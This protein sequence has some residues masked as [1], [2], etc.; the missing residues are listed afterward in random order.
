[1]S[2]ALGVLVIVVG[3]VVSVALHEIGHMVPAKRFGVLVP[4][5]S[6]GFGPVLWQ[7]TWRGTTYA[8]RAVLLGG[9]VRIVGMF[10]P[11]RPGTRTTNRH[12]R[13]TLAQE[14]R[15]ASAEEVPP[16]QESHA[17]HRLSAPRKVVV[18]ASGPATNL[19]ICIALLAVAMMGIGLA[20]PS[21]TLQETTATVSTSAGDVEGPARGAGIEAG[22]TVISWDGTATPSWQDLR[23]AIAASDGAPVPV[24]VERAGAQVDLTVT[25]VRNAQGEWAAGIIAG[26][27]YVSTGPGAVASTTWQMFTGTASVVVR[28]P[29][30]VWGVG[31]SLFT[32][33]ER[34]PNGVVSVVGVGRVAG[35]ITQ[36]GDAAGA[37][38]ARQT[39]A[40]LLALLASLNMALFVFNLIPL[41]PL[42]GGHVAGA[43]YEGVRRTWARLRGAPDP[44]PAD[45]ARMMPL[46]HAVVGLL[47]AMT[48]LL[49][50]AD[51]VDPVRLF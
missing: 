15:L 29:Q 3:L 50:A 5:Y 27:D 30:A 42:D 39:A 49:V 13:P 40:S 20:T 17:F 32:S 46:T 23:T 44:G 41:P 26:I 9:Y 45:T 2:F 11:A 38:G 24:V 43:V 28:L 48:V 34:D 21:T 25:P 6:V 8:L 35:E 1:M 37:S 31:R 16:G 36:A 10:A 7:R 22:D 4:M 18:M 19:L 14:A 12:G 33:Q 47:L 51:L